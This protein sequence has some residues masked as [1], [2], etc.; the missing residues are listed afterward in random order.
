MNFEEAVKIFAHDGI[1]HLAARERAQ[2][3]GRVLAEPFDRNLHYPII[4]I[5]VFFAML[6]ETKVMLDAVPDKEDETYKQLE[7]YYNALKVCEHWN[8]GIFPLTVRHRNWW[9]GPHLTF[10]DGDSR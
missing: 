6:P 1:L 9:K 2:N 8:I 3:I 5:H 7:D 4:Y 10:P